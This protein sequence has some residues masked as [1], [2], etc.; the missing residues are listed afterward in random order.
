MHAVEQLFTGQ[1]W[2]GGLT[3]AILAG[4]LVRAKGPFIEGWAPGIGFCSR[5][6][7]EAAILLIGA[8]LNLASVASL[9]WMAPL[10]IGAVVVAS[11]VG[12][13]YLGR[14]AGLERRLAVLLA[15]GN[16]ICG[17]SAIAAVAPTIGAKTDDV[18]KSITFTSAIGLMSV[19]LL[20]AIG[21]LLAMSE[22]RFGVWAGLTVYAVPQVVAITAP[23]GAH[24]EDVGVFVKLVRVAMLAPVC[25]IAALVFLGRHPAGEARCGKPRMYSIIPWFVLGFL[26]LAA[27]R[28]VGLLPSAW[29]APIGQAAHLLTLVSMAALGLSTDLTGLRKAAPRVG[30]VVGL[31]ALSL[32]AACLTLL[33]LLHVG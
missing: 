13:Y 16:S 8:S 24:A 5:R 14:F 18:A 25:I 23:Y 12:T 11:L 3:F 27:I 33:T 1:T 31:S 4:A 20:P 6:L 10:L 19:I 15:C 17:N 7:L 9:G 28:S 21:H 32:G 30:A 22:Q 29:A 2:L 26:A